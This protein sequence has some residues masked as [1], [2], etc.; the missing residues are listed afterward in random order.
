M[1]SFNSKKRSLLAGAVIEEQGTIKISTKRGSHLTDNAIIEALKKCDFRAAAK[2]AAKK[3]K[4]VAKEQKKT[5]SCE[6]TK[7]KLRRDRDTETPADVRHLVKLAPRRANLRKRLEERRDYRRSIIRLRTQQL[8]GVTEEETASEL[9]PLVAIAPR[10]R[11]L[12]WRLKANRRG[13]RMARML[14][15]SHAAAMASYAW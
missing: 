13:R 7:M 10:R 2:A 9:Q 14:R 3:A 5:K 6:K 8:R 11:V 15:A 12:F 4:T 1:T